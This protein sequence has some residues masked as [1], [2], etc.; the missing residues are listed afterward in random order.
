MRAAHFVRSISITRLLAAISVCV[1]AVVLLPLGWLVTNEWAAY[2]RASTA[3]AAFDSYRATLLV[4]EKVSVERGPT[5]GALGE[6][7]P[8][9]AVR[10]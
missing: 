1:F 9:P 3:L 7:L 8:I 5:N 6:D 10:V 2:S 4:M